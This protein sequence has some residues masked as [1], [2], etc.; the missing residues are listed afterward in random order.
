M[1]PAAFQAEYISETNGC[2]IWILHTTV[3]AV[4]I[5]RHCFNHSLVGCCHL[6]HDDTDRLRYMLARPSVRLEWPKAL[7]TELDV[8]SFVGRVVLGPCWW[9]QL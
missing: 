9:P 4:G 1:D 3:T 6:H 8:K 7:P 2:P 5:S